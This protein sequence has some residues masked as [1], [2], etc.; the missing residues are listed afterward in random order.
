MKPFKF[1]LLLAAYWAFLSTLATLT[2]AQATVMVN[3]TNMTLAFPTVAQFAASNS[4]ATSAQ[5]IAQG[6]ANTNHAASVLQSATNYTLTASNSLVAS[7]VARQPAS[8]NLTNWSLFSTNALK[9]TLTTNSTQFGNSIQLTLKDGVRSTNNNIY[10]QLRIFKSDGTGQTII[11]GGNPQTM[12]AGGFSPRTGDFSMVSKSNFWFFGNW[13]EHVLSDGIG[14]FISQTNVFFPTNVQFN[15]SVLI[16]SSAGSGKVLTS[17]ASGYATWQVNSA[18]PASSILTNLSGTGANTNAYIPGANITLT[19][20]AGGIVTIAGSGGAA[21]TNLTTIAAGSAVITN[22]L[23]LLTAPTNA[24]PNIAVT[25]NPTTGALEDSP[26]PSVNWYFQQFRVASPWN[27]INQVLQITN[28]ATASQVWHLTGQNGNGLLG[29]YQPIHSIW[30]L[31]QHTNGSISLGDYNA[32]N[33]TNNG[34]F[35]ALGNATNAAPSI[36]VTRNPSTGALEDS[37]VPSGGGASYAPIVNALGS[38]N[39]VFSAATNALFTFTLT[40]NTV[41]TASNYAAGAQVSLF[42]SGDMAKA[43]TRTITFPGFT[44][45]EGVPASVLSNKLMRVDLTS[46]STTATNTIAVYGSQQ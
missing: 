24:S 16:P 45:L 22:S 32:G 38:S 37:A 20:N 7:I 10:G 44:W 28:T 43:A 29:W 36:M 35:F 25:R 27:A 3:R 15:S 21:S 12:S 33:F 30:G 40:S 23:R 26:A 9:S 6:A 14:L 5:V 41:F 18:Q 39:I 34:K 8:D 2:R 4:I 46:L 1:F 11:E 31:L 19:T 13:A 17:D 42:I